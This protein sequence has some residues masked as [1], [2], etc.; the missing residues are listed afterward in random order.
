MSPAPPTGNLPSFPGEH[1]HPS[2][3]QRPRLSHQTQMRVCLVG[4]SFLVS[5]TRHHWPSLAPL[6]VGPG[7]RK[8]IP[9]HDLQLETRGL[10]SF[11]S[12]L[13]HQPA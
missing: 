3:S 13:S 7:C 5:H 9:F 1:T 11:Y 10:R 2:G 12:P 8:R 4:E 6:E